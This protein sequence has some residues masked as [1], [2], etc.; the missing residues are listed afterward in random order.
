MT[1]KLKLI[2]THG[3]PGDEERYSKATMNREFNG[4]A[5]A[6]GD[7]GARSDH[8]VDA[9]FTEK[10]RN[11]KETDIDLSSIDSSDKRIPRQRPI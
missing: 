3:C 7:A 9:L 10:T 4:L 2:G 1:S 8:A 11:L 5:G 6:G